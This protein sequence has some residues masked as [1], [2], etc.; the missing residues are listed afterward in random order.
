[1]FSRTKK[2]SSGFTLIELLVVTTIIILLSAIGLVSFQNA[3]QNARNGKRKADIETYRQAL[4]LF[5]SDVGSY[6]EGTITAVADELVQNSYI[7]APAPTETKSGRRSYS[8]SSDGNDFCICALLEGDSSPGNSD[9]GCVFGA[10][11]YYCAKNP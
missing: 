5:R 1:M 4:V 11:D 7:S 8:Y 6:P 9:P 10:G 2:T 3:G